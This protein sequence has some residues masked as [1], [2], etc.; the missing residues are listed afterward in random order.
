VIEAARLG[1]R[2]A[3]LEAALRTVRAAIVE[4]AGAHAVDN[5]PTV[6][7]VARLILDALCAADDT[8]FIGKFTVDNPV[9]I[10]GRFDLAIAADIIRTKLL[11]T[12]VQE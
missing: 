10:D 9:T 2:V 1:K 11:I 4:K 8:A 7:D 3:E 5:I 12:N 6:E